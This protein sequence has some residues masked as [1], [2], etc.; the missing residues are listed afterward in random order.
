VPIDRLSTNA[1]GN[2]GVKVGPA[3][4]VFAEDGIMKQAD[5]VLELSGIA[6]TFTVGFKRRRSEVLSNVNLSINRGEIFA[7]L[8]PNGAGKS[9]LLKIML[10]LIKPSRG[11][12][13]LLGKPLGDLSARR[14]IG[15]QPEQPY[16]YPTLT[17]AETLDLLAGLSSLP[18]GEKRN[19]IDLVIE[20][21]SL[22]AQLK[23]PVKKLSRGWLQRL[24]LGG[25]LLANPEILFLDE[26]LGGLDPEARHGIKDLLRH[27]RDAGTTI[28]FNSHVLPDVETL[29][30]RVAL[31]KEGRIIIE[32]PLEDLLTRGEGSVALEFTAA[33]PIAP[34]PGCTLIW[35]RPRSGQFCWSIGEARNRLAPI[36]TDLIADGARIVS[37]TPERISLESF[38]VQCMTDEGGRR[39]GDSIKL[40]N[41]MDRDS[42][43]SRTV[44]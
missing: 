23:T 40:S 28:F 36:L 31:L 2:P 35:E 11:S 13:S 9:T 39:E 4:L 34:L 26:P 33:K 14:S 27:L 8:G 1:L 19:R 18:A 22:A 30:D 10:G 42:A 29:A 21:C 17:A 24:T 38:F 12:G 43:Q 5:Q 16:L 15:Y 3:Q 32:G 44:A 20:R 6:K 41:E 25:A 37:I 7:L